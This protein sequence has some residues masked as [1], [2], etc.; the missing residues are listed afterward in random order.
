M[1]QGKKPNGIRT[2]IAI[3]SFVIVFC[4]IFIWVGFWKAQASESAE[5]IVDL[6]NSDVIHD[7]RIRAVEDA[8]IRTD[9]RLTNMEEDIEEILEEVKK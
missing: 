1:N 3:A 7:E 6:K 9:G 4:G 8:T 5:D 2:W